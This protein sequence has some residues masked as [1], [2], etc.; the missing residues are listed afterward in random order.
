MPI[1]PYSPGCGPKGTEHVDKYWKYKNNDPSTA[2][3]AAIVAG[4]IFSEIKDKINKRGKDIYNVR[5]GAII[6][7]DLHHETI[8]QLARMLTV[9]VKEIGQYEQENSGDITN[10]FDSEKNEEKQEE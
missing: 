6:V 4:E 9:R 5:P 8:R 7:Q 1:Y 2:Y 3:Y 10:Y